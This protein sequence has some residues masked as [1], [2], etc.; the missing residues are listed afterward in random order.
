M[1]K[2]KRSLKLY[3]KVMAGLGF[4]LILLAIP[5]FILEICGVIDYGTLLLW[6]CLS[7]SNVLMN[8]LRWENHTRMNVVFVWL[9]SG[10]FVLNAIMLVLR[11]VS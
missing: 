8:C 5:M 3:E 2:E 6:M 4:L 9:W 11:L 1:E 7:L 10:M